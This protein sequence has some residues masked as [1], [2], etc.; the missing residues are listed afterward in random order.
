MNTELQNDDTPRDIGSRLELMVDDYLIE[1]LVGTRLQLQTPQKMPRAKSPLLGAYTTIIKDGDLFR[2]FYR[3]DDLAYAGK[4]FDGDSSVMT[5]YAESA[6]GHEWTFPHLGLVEV[7]GSRANNVILRESPACHTF[8][9]VLDQ[10]PGVPS[11]ERFKALAGLHDEAVAVT[12]KT[13][14]TAIP[15]GIKG[16]LYAYASPDAIHWRKISPEPVIPSSAAGEFGF[17]SQN[18]SFWSEHEGC[19]VCYFRTWYMSDGGSFAWTPAL[20]R[21]ISRVTS[22]DYRTWGPTQSMS[23][24]EPDEHLY[25]N[26]THP[27]FRAPHIYIATPTRFMANR[28]E[29]TDIMFMTARGSAPYSRLFKEAFLR[30]GLDSSRWGN[31]ANYVALNVVPTSPVEMSIY[32]D[33][34]GDRYVLRTDGFAAVNTPLAGGEMVTRPLR[35]TGTELVINYSTSAAGRIRVEIQDA[36]GIPIPGFA[37]DD[38]PDIIGDSIEHGVAWKPGA[39]LGRL[40]GQPV[41]LRFVMQ[42][43]DLFALRFR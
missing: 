10:R 29:S 15:P 5:A 41:R 30:P 17:D 28:G 6:D 34:S 12:R 11:D 38:C 32:H 40:A 19:Y 7:A 36:D 4:R 27:Y 31:R 8:S 33:H 25:T 18:V 23:P 21:S 22:P 20:K 37:A 39:D 1:R 2:A 43:A 26:Q 42:D 14:P 13:D 24:N 9:A 3:A 35:F 16:G